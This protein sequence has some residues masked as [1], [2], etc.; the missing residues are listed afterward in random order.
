MIRKIQS[1][2]TNKNF[3][4]LLTEEQKRQIQQTI[5]EQNW[6][7]GRIFLGVMLIMEAALILFYDLPTLKTAPTESLWITRSYLILHL[8]LGIT[9]IAG[10]VILF[11]ELRKLDSQKRRSRDL[12]SP[13]F[14][15]LL[16]IYLSIITGLDQI[17]NGQISVFI[18]GLLVP[19]VLI[20][21]RPPINYLVYTIPYLIFVA[22]TYLLQADPTL[23][24]ANIVNGSVFF[25]CVLLISRFV[26]ENQVSH[27]MKNIKL[28]EANQQLSF[29]SSFD[30]L[31]R[32]SNRRNFEQAVDQLELAANGEKSVILIQLDIDHFKQVNDKFGHQAGD[33]VL[34][35]VADI[36]QTNIREQDLAARWGG[37]EFL[38]LIRGYSLQQGK[39]LGERIRKM[40]AEKIFVVDG[41]QISVTVSVGV[42]F[43]ATQTLK[44]DFEQAYHQV[45]QA[46]Y[47]AKEQGRN[48]VVVFE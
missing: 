30:P 28:E 22:G 45:D 34:R 17:S 10:I 16:L 47:Q 13:L 3:S 33:E 29:L 26:Y 7:K 31:T 44:I 25:I 35:E 1:S 41:K 20:T 24:F 2:T 11:F 32:L 48:T 27:L 12:Y 37:E 39:Q 21:L 6:R 43:M 15:L 40:I 5:T 19:S 42:S 18:I 4:I 9:N 38:I 23:R 46:L 36:I 8:L 14:V